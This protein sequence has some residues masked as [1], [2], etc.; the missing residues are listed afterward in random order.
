MLCMLLLL[1]SRF[2]RVRLYDPIN[3]NPPGSAVPGILQ[4]RTL[5]WGAISLSHT[6]MHPKSLQSCP[7]LCDPI[8][9]NPPGSSVHGI[10]QARILEWVA[11][12]CSDFMHRFCNFLRIWSYYIFYFLIWS[13]LS[14]C[15]LSFNISMCQPHNLYIIIIWFKLVRYIYGFNFAY[16]FNGY[17]QILK[18]LLTKLVNFQMTIMP[19]VTQISG[20]YSYRPTGVNISPHWFTASFP[21]FCACCAGAQSSLTLCDPMDC[22]PPGSSVH[23][24][25]QTRILE[26]VAISSSR[27]SSPPRVWTYFSCVSWIGRRILYH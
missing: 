17:R 19:P 13:F 15:L 6:Y 2:S 24:I 9:G 4:A 7:T 21:R 11:I 16:I 22:S 1:L 25:L 10:H 23:E 18:F 8:D 20:H 26:Q 27:G 3:G 12:S 14:I 5:E